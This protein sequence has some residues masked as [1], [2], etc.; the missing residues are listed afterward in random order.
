MTSAKAY[1]IF[2]SLSPELSESIFQD[3][4]D[5]HR[6]VYKTILVSLAQEKRL[7]PVFVQ[8]KPAKLQMQ[9]MGQ[10]CKLKGVNGVTEQL[11]QLWLLKSQQ[12]ML[13]TFLTKMGIEHDDEGTA[14]E[15]PETMDAK[16]LKSAADALLKDHPRE[17]VALYL[18]VFQLQ[19]PGGWEELAKLL[20]TD[21]RLALGEPPA[22]EAEPKEETEP[23]PAAETKAEVE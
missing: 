1:Q 17:T 8:R 15:L 18:H 9:W 2:Q 22:K 10:T 23:E 3:L 19:Q 21:E 12:E 16:K 7:R 5:N 13:K 20:E 14:E 11:L 6:E 4:R